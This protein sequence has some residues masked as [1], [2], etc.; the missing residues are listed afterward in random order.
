MEKDPLKFPLKEN[1]DQIE[2]RLIELW[3]DFGH[4]VMGP[5]KKR[6][7]ELS[8]K[9]LKELIDIGISYMCIFE[10]NLKKLPEDSRKNHERGLKVIRETLK[11]ANKQKR[12]KGWSLC[13]IRKN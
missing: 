6:I 10:Y 8:R 5:L 2:K 11:I 3:L 12:R 4:D 7:G 9:K 1:V 13:W